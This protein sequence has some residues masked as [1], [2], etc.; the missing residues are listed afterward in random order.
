MT[1][2]PE[3]PTASAAHGTRHALDWHDWGIIAPLLALSSVPVGFGLYRL[4][5]LGF[6]AAPA[7][8]ELRAFG[9]PVPIAIH[10]ASTALFVVLG[11]FQ[12][13]PGFRQR[14][15]QWHRVVGRILIPSALTAALSGLWLSFFFP[16]PPVDGDALAVIRLAVSSAWTLFVML[17]FA[18]IL[19]GD[20]Q[21]HRAW[22]LRAY[23]LA[24]GAGTQSVLLIAWMALVGPL[25]VTTKACVMGLAW[26]LNLAV[27]ELII[28]RRGFGQ[29]R[30]TAHSNLAGVEV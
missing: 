30:L 28:R 21:A 26:G 15:P 11:A 7:T 3:P 6:A 29:P 22:M 13:A 27:A 23:A 8:D 1:N 2:R 9:D 19:G 4:A 17:G 16:L 14:R 10:I 18:T 5:R 12:L 24:Q 20:V 25:D